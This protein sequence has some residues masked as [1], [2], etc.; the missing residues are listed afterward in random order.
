[1][2]FYKFLQ[3]ITPNCKGN[4]TLVYNLYIRVLHPNFQ[5]YAIMA[6][7]RMYILEVNC[8][9]INAKCN[10]RVRVLLDVFQGLE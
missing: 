4:F 2:I 5:F 10:V 9:K 8:S 3:K 6:I 7:L 1:M